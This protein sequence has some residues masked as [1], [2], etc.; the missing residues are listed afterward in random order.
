M[1]NTRSHYGSRSKKESNV[2]LLPGLQPACYF[3]KS[4]KLP[5]L[6]ISEHTNS[7]TCQQAADAQVFWFRHMFLLSAGDAAAVQQLVVQLLGDK[8]LEVQELAARTL[9]GLIQVCQGQACLCEPRPT[10]QLQRDT[11]SEVGFGQYL[12]CIRMSACLEAQGI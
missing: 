10:S 9:S 12:L 11:S 8:K 2:W 5:T 4:C 1:I 6:A 3:Q 7:R